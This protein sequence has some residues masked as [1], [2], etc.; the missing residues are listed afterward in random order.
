MRDRLKSIAKALCLFFLGFAIGILV[1]ARYRPNHIRFE[2]LN[3]KKMYVTPLE[4]DTLEWVGEGIKQK[5]MKIRFLGD[6][7][8]R[9]SPSFDGTSCRFQPVSHNPDGSPD[10]ST[11]SYACPGLDKKSLC[12][13]PG[14]GGGSRT[15]GHIRLISDKLAFIASLVN[16]EE[17]EKKVVKVETSGGSTIPTDADPFPQIVCDQG[18]ATLYPDPTGAPGDTVTAQIGQNVEWGGYGFSF[19]LPAGTCNETPGSV[20][21]ISSSN[22][23]QLNCTISANAT[24]LTQIPVTTSCSVSNDLKMNLRII[25]APAH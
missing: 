19:K 1:D 8:C 17:D 2:V 4:G 7:P 20:T 6:A 25:P 23:I 9:N 18:K 16:G 21:S 13:D 14:V 10:G 24:S 15:G 22:P 3:S 5:D 11:Y 12:V